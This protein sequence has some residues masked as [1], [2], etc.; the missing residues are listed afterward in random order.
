MTI[1]RVA[2]DLET[3]CNVTDC[4]GF[5]QYKLCEHALS[6]WHARITTIGL[7][8]DGGAKVIRE[9]DQLNKWLN[10]NPTTLFTN[11]RFKFDWLMLAANGIVIP[12]GRYVDDTHL[13]ADLS[14]IKIP[15]HWL[16]TFNAGRGAATRQ[17]GRHSLKAL[18]P[19]Y[20]GV[21]EW[22]SDDKDN[23]EYVLK[24]CEYVLQ[25]EP[26]LKE[27]LDKCGGSEFYQKRL[28]PYTKMLME[29]EFRGLLIDWT[30]FD[31]LK[32]T[33]E[34]E[35]AEAYQALKTL[36]AGA[37]ERYAADER[38][39]LVTHYWAMA[40]AKGTHLDTSPRYQKLLENALKKQTEFNFDSPTQLKTLMSKHLALD[41][42][43]FE[44]EESTEKAVL[45]RLAKDGDKGCTLLL[46]W[47]AA[48]DQLKFL[49][50]Y[51]E[52]HV[53]GVVHPSYHPAQFTDG[54]NKGGTRTGRLS[55]SK[56]NFQQV[57]KRL[58]SVFR[59][60]PGYK[61]VGFDL[62]SIEAKLIALYTADP[63]FY[64]ITA[65]DKSF[66]DVNTKIFFGFTDPLE[67]IKD[68]YPKHRQATKRIG[69]SLCYGAG[70]R[71]IQKSFTEDGFFFTPAECKRFHENFKRQYGKVTQFH[72]ELTRL[73]EGGGTVPNLLGRPIKIQDPREAYMK[74]F[75]RLIQSSASD[76]CLE[77]A[78]RAM[79]QMRQ[80]N[81]ECHP[82]LFV[83]DFVCFEVEETKA[84]PAAEII[85]G[86]MVDFNLSN[87]LGPITLKV[88][89]G[90]MS[91][92]EG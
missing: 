28:L 25:L 78:R 1:A 82:V 8:W 86:A 14:T 33:I 44:G 47:R 17:M 5:G 57:N 72:D 67:T 26:I 85:S 66:H 41:I 35:Q 27:Q 73:F 61:L 55:S 21:E 81:I 11:H 36:W 71:R 24:D 54:L 56:P 15:Q 63:A 48:R 10:E 34:A 62:A 59:A 20:L 53:N 60:R 18:A 7:K 91:H 40:A 37:L 51:N 80:G 49:T 39:A 83:H 30:R 65:T 45:K 74:G 89:G 29:A 31:K 3:V 16:E 68:K 88:E 38:D 50:S 32:E 90:V 52:L 84:E 87:E 43:N 70:Y 92:W 9:L 22:E 4:K 12:L 64:D 42:R 79:E 19:Y 2:L 46:A 76:L 77:G 58:S 69:F 13:M 6:P 75:N 23:D